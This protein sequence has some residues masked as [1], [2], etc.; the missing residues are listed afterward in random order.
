M[1]D[2]THFLDADLE[3]KEVDDECQLPE[4][5][6]DYAGDDED[7]ETYRVL[8]DRTVK[9]FADQAYRTI[10]IC[11]RDMSMETFEQL[12]AENNDFEKDE[13]KK[14]LETGLTGIGIFGLQDPLRPG[15]KESIELCST[16]G[17]RVI[18][19][20]G[21]NLDTAKAISRNAGIIEKDKMKLPN[22]CMTGAY[23]REAVSNLK[24][25][26]DPKDSTKT[27]DVVGDMKAFREI[28]KDLRVLAR[29]SP[30]DK[31]ILVTGMQASEGV[32]AVTGDGTN[33]APALTKADVGFAMGIAGTDVAKGA[34]DIILMDD[35]F[36]SI[37]VA[38]RYGRSVFDNVRKFL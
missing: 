14:V 27:I 29:C 19:C 2:V 8:V 37:V 30:E 33:D 5:L 16:A 17:I 20:T 18:M 10:L 15:I 12:K 35:N 1:P 22:A 32:V 36:T 24:Q 34:S 4:A 11:Y 7:G 28:K 38:L 9:S 6:D 31:Y 25:I 13:D 26:P 3:A 21:D 23:F